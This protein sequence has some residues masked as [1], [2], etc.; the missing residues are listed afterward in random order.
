MYGTDLEKLASLYAFKNSPKG[1]IKLNQ[2]PNNHYISRILA[3]VFDIKIAEILSFYLIDLFLVPID[4]EILNQIL[5]YILTIL[6]FILYDTSFQFFIK[7][8]LGKKIFNIHIVSNENENE[9]I[10]I[11]KVLYRSFYVCFFGLGFLIPKISTLFALFTL[12]YIFRNGTT[13]WDKVLRLKIPFKPISIG[14]MVLIAFCF[15]LLFNS[16]YQLIKGY[17]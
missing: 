8:S 14:R 1:K 3:K 12:Y 17:F 6:V 4:G 11:T 15:L 5:P 9:E 13:H 7:G 16:Y 10:P 2:K